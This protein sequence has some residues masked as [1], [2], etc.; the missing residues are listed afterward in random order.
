MRKSGP[1]AVVVPTGALGGGATGSGAGSGAAGFGVELEKVGRVVGLKGGGGLLPK[2]AGLAGS[3]G[4]VS[5]FSLPKLG[6][7]GAVPFEGGKFKSSLSPEIAEPERSSEA[8]GGAVPFEGGKF[9]SSLSPEI[10]EPERPSETGGAGSVEFSSLPEGDSKA[11]LASGMLPNLRVSPVY[12]PLSNCS[13]NSRARLGVQSIL[14]THLLAP[15]FQASLA[16]SG[17]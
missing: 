17:R 10:V 7:D 16:R 15:A 4:A 13:I 2:K 14:E 1:L 9:K 6:R 11:P 8:G 12:S 5:S 3:E